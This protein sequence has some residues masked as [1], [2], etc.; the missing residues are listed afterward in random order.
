MWC[1]VPSLSKC[2]Y[3][4]QQHVCMRVPIW[5]YCKCIHPQIPCSDPRF[6][7]SP[8]T[9]GSQKRAILRDQCTKLGG[10]EA[11]LQRGAKREVARS[12]V[13]RPPPTVIVWPGLDCG[14]H[15]FSNG[16]YCQCTDGYIRALCDSPPA[17]GVAGVLLSNQPPRPR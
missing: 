6:D 12:Q 7:F 2:T 8:R 11:L 17:T 3:L 4:L 1:V 13:L 16:W 9:A 5:A 14:P 15:G 10:T